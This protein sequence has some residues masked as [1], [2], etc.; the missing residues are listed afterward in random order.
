M[1]LGEL[2]LK[3][4][5]AQRGMAIR[6]RILRVMDLTRP[7]LRGVGNSQ[8]VELDV[9]GG[10]SMSIFFPRSVLVLILGAASRFRGKSICL[11]FGRGQ[12]VDFVL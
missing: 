12:A 4:L 8:E 2:S 5:W 3:Y 9:A 11:S 10:M 6:G 7:N 1:D